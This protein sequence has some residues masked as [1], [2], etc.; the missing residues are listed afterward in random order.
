M[1]KHVSEHYLEMFW[2]DMNHREVLESAGGV[3]RQVRQA[4]TRYEEKGILINLIV[5]SFKLRGSIV[6]NFHYTLMM[7]F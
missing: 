3:C 7:I 6:Y 1:C 5:L 4:F 2:L